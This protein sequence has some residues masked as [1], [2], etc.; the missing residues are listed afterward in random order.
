MKKRKL[1][2]HWKNALLRISKQES[3]IANLSRE[4][5]ALMEIAK[6]VAHIGIDFGY[7]AF[8]LGQ[9]HIDEARR[10]CDAG[11]ETK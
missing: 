7:G 3:T 10:L 1:K 5:D 11:I 4:K 8:E 2:Y 9:S 6:A